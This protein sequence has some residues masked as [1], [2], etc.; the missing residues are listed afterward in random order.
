MRQTDE[1]R[2]ETRRNAI[3]AEGLHAMH[4]I[5]TCIVCMAIV[6]LSRRRPIED[7]FIATHYC[8]SVTKH[9]ISLLCN[10][11]QFCTVYCS[12]EMC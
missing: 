6:K 4:N 12:P 8:I 5:S 3:Y 1:A 7:D 10:I 9:Y 11:V 2:R